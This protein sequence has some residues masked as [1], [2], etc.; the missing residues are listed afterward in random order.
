MSIG[1]EL[2]FGSVNDAQFGPIVTIGAGGIWV[3][4]IRD[5][6]SLMPPISISA[7]RD[8]ISRLRVYPLLT[9]ARGRPQADLARLPTDTDDSDDR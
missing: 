3:E 8:A 9:G 1:T 5:S 7:A 2:F 4:T 6:V